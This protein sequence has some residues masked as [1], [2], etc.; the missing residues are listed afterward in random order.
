MSDFSVG[1]GGMGHGWEW[2]G[3]YLVGALEHD[4]YV[5]FQSIS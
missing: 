1:K 4:F 5:P 2:M 3:L